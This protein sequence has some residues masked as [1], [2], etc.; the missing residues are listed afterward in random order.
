MAQ[1]EKK[2]GEIYIAKIPNPLAQKTNKIIEERGHTR[3]WFINT[4]VAYFADNYDAVMD[5]KKSPPQSQ[6]AVGE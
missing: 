6:S 4:A 3:N 1:K 2:S 5:W